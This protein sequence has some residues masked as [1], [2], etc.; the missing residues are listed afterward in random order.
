MPRAAILDIDGTLVDTNYHHALGWFRAF[1]KHGVT[2]PLWRIHRHIGLAGDLF[3][4]ALAGAEVDRS[5]GAEIRE[6]EGEIYADLVDEVTLLDGAREF[7]FALKDAG[8][9]VVLASSAKEEELGHYLDMLDLKDVLDGWTSSADVDTAK[10]EPDVILVAHDKA[11]GGEA[12]VIGDSTWDCKAAARAGL[13]SIGVLTGGFS[14][15]ELTAEGASQV[16]E[17]VEEMR[18]RL[19]DTLLLRPTS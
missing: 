17:S 13:P 9:P 5:I 16:F 19:A 10:P 11:G 14:A 4:E 15:A 2:V 12:V 7:V 3:V 8:C 1:R 6:S 18:R